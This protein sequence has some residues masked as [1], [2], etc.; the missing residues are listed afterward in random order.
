[1]PE[2]VYQEAQVVRSVHILLISLI[3]AVMVT[4]SACSNTSPVACAPLSSPHAAVQKSAP[5]P[6]ENQPR[7]PDEYLVTLAPDVDKG[8]IFQYY[9]NFGIKDIFALG[10]ETFLLVLIHDPGPQKM[11]ALVDEDSRVMAVQPN[12]I[13]WDNRSGRITK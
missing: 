5:V 3:V 13:Y 1:V 12:L 9:G 10:G 6:T 4:V 8:I 2:T 7:V 11:V